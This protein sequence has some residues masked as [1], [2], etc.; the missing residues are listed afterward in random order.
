MIKV[1]IT[2]VASPRNH[3]YRTGRSLIEI[4]PYCIGSNAALSR[5]HDLDFEPLNCVAA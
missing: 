1:Q 2:L 3:L 4:G 5:L